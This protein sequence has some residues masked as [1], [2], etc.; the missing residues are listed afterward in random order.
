MRRLLSLS[1]VAGGLVLAVGCT[2]Q[3]ENR[4]VSKTEAS[5]VRTT[6]LEPTGDAARA[7]QSSNGSYKVRFE[8]SKGDFVVRVEPE[9]APHGADRFRGLVEAGFYDGCRFFRVVPDFMVQW[10]INGNPKTQAIWRDRN[11]PD[12]PPRQSNTRGRITFATS[13]PDSRST[14]VF[15]NYKDNSF[16]DSQGF[17]PF[18]EVVEGLA[19]VDSINAEYGEDPNQ[20]LI[21]QQGNAYLKRA[22]PNLDYIISAK[23]V[24]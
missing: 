15:I 4:A 7:D 24:K 18:G 12:D 17:A 2:G 19:V 9:W 8:T 10:G 3:Q 16:L 20:G 11:I 23:I 13:G 14:Q 5:R 1:I 22:F 21:Q 6:S